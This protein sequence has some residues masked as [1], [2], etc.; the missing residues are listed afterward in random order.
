MIYQKHIFSRI[1]GLK[2]WLSA[3][4]TRTLFQD[5]GGSTP[6]ASNTDPTKLWRDLSGNSNDATASSDAKRPTY[7]SSI[8]N[9]RPALYFDASDDNMSTPSMT[10]TTGCIFVVG[11][12]SATGSFPGFC[13]L[14]PT[15]GDVGTNGILN[16]SQQ[17]VGANWLFGNPSTGS[18][19]KFTAQDIANN[20][21]FLYYAQWGSV[22]G[23]VIVRF[24][25]T[26]LT[27][28]GGASYAQPSGSMPV[29]LA[30]GYSSNLWA[31][32][33][34]EIA[35]LNRV[36]TSTEYTAIEKYLAK[37]WGL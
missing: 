35:M 1:P 2:L 5:T 27:P 23:D 34:G 13:K 25:Q 30:S 21:N 28:D 11:R 3:Q 12:R 15:A 19:S 6:V 10:L 9:S 29:H 16:C 33:L 32:Y 17:T 8:I 7:T 4:T 26:T 22:V 18:Y 14:A 37:G 31:G 36:P 20:T 24:N